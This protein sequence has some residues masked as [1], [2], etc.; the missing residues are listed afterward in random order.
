[1]WCAMSSPLL[2]G[3]DLTYI[4]Q[5]TIDII[6]NPELISVNQDGLGLQS[7]VVLHDNAG[8]VLAK[9]IEKRNGGVRAVTLYNPSDSAVTFSVP[10]EIMGFAGKVAVRDLN[11]RADLGVVESLEMNIPAHSAKLLRVEGRRADCTLYEAE[12]A[13]VQ[14]FTR[15]SEKEITK[16]EAWTGASCGVV[17]T[18]V[19]GR[20]TGSLEWKDVY[21]SK[22]GK[23]AVT[24]TCDAPVGTEVVL[25]V[26][27][28]EH[29]AT[30]TSEG[31]SEVGFLAKFRKGVNSVSFGSFNTQLSAVDCFRLHL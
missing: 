27:G 29:S 21:L 22:G 2:I 19:G 23:Y 13:Y 5:E 25:M 16:Y 6:T 31:L 4:P 8:Y 18:S 3:C 12:W 7:R 28:V 15:I 17:A 20:E 1:M 24:V 11:E 10:V 14:D 9:D 26:N 30:V